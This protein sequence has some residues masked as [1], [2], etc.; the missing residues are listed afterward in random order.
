MLQFFE[1]GLQL[2]AFK[3]NIKWLNNCMTQ[4]LR[5]LPYN[6]RSTGR[7]YFAGLY[8]FCEQMVTACCE[9]EQL[10]VE[11][12]NCGLENTSDNEMGIVSQSE[13]KWPYYGICLSH[14][15][16]KNG[17]LT[18]ADN[19]HVVKCI[20]SISWGC[21]SH[22]HIANVLLCSVFRVWQLA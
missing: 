1:L 4:S 5:T 10:T 8:L 14:M 11:L 3:P 2:C 15:Y 9:L 18:Q 17:Y 22:C 20:N 6:Y 16:V 12:F 19:T 13:L 7:P 21:S